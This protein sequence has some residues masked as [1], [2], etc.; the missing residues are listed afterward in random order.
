MHPFIVASF[1]AQ[2]V[3][4]DHMACK[5]CETSTI[6]KDNGVD[7]FFVKETWLSAQGGEAKLLN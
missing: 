7:H 6:I 3:T 1:N 5:R 2:S 4:G